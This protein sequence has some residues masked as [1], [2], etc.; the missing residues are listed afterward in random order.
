MSRKEYAAL[1]AR[2][3]ELERKCLEALAQMMLSRLGADVTIK[4]CKQ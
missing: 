4:S 1:T 3:C 2:A